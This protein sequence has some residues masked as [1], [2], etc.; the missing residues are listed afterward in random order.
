[1][2]C[3]VKTAFFNFHCVRLFAGSHSTHRG[4]EP[5]SENIAAG[6]APR[7]SIKLSAHAADLISRLIAFDPANRIGCGGGAAASS[8]S[9]L[10]RATSGSADS[11]ND[12]SNTSGG[13][14][15]GSGSDHGSD[16]DA[17][18]DIFAHPFFADIDWERMRDGEVPSPYIAYLQQQPQADGSGVG[19]GGD[20]AVAAIYPALRADET[21]KFASAMDVLVRFVFAAGLSRGFS[22]SSLPLL[23]FPPLVLCF[24]VP[25]FVL[26][27][28]SSMI[29]MRLFVRHQNNQIQF[30]DNDARRQ[31]EL[32]FGQGLGL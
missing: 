14:H 24:G 2:Y 20:A 28:S 26:I 30:D 18:A 17:I 9:S 21:P 19:G 13:T 4:I 7:L 25:C 1:L 11:G 27:V 29:C 32:A 10:V 22:I 12:S 3:L 23:I 6:N 15:T 31:L 5:R 16:A 8:P